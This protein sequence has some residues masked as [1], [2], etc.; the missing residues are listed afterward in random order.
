MRGGGG[1]IRGWGWV[2]REQARACCS[3][4]LRRNSA[5]CQ[6]RRGAI[7]GT[8][9]WQS[10]ASGA[11]TA[12]PLPVL[13]VGGKGTL[14][15]LQVSPKLVCRGRSAAQAASATVRSCSRRRMEGKALK[16]G[17][18]LQAS[19]QAG[20]QQWSRLVGPRVHTRAGRWWAGCKSEAG[21]STIPVTRAC[22][23]GHAP[24]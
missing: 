22:S 9:R 2:G 3:C 14:P 8:C 11:H 23:R 6:A 12:G 20:C 21:A 17:M 24:C 13:L 10:H 7:G 19:Q 18:L 1:G 16:T 15:E 5:T 4:S